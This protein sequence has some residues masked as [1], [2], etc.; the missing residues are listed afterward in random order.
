M[1]ISAYF[2]HKHG[3]IQKI[4]II[5]WAM[6]KYMINEIVKRAKFPV[7]STTA[8]LTLI[9]RMIRIELILMEFQELIKFI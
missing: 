8:I 3:L 2:N 9:L 5:F 1:H 7:T 6:K 4:Y